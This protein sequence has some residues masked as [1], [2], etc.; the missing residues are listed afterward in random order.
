MTSSQSR[1]SDRSRVLAAA[2][3]VT[4]NRAASLEWYGRPSDVF[5]GK[6]PE[7]LVS[8]GRADDVVGYLDSVSSGFVG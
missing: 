4:S 6:T 5:G 3:R 7:D 2:D 1:E 8:L